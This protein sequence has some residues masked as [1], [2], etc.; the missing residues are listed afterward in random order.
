M[1][2][3]EHGVAHT[4]A[5]PKPKVLMTKSFRGTLEAVARSDPAAVE[6]ALETVEEQ[7]FATGLWLLTP[8]WRS[9]SLG[10]HRL[11]RYSEARWT[12]R[13][14]SRQLSNEWTCGGDWT[15]SSPCGT[16]STETP[17]ECGKSRRQA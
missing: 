15:R 8:L 12:T 3:D 10:Y 2:V 16:T 14:H 6:A 17:H 7:L 4:V 5:L 11:G 1:W 13:P 9:S